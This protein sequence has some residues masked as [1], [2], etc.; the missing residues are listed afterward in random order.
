MDNSQNYRTQPIIYINSQRLP[1]SLTNL[2][3]PNQTLL[4]FLRNTCK[5]TGSKLGCGEG[6]CGA[7]TVLLSRY[8]TSKQ[9]IVHGTV[10]ACLFPV[11]AADGCHV[12]TVEGVGSWRKEY[13]GLLT[14]TSDGSCN[15]ATIVEAKGSDGSDTK[16]KKEDYL[17][18]IQRAMIDMH[19]SQCGIVLENI[20]NIS[21]F[22]ALSIGSSGPRGGGVDLCRKRESCLFDN[23]C[24]PNRSDE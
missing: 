16:Q 20:V 2:A 4:D 12:T 23:N 5:L 19:G 6:G 22:N 1:P 11:L 24:L 21:V 13:R 10:N 8:D 17:H 15:N 14:A 18:P 3:R 9:K 7:C